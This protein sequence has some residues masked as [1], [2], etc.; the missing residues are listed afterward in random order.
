MLAE[1]EMSKAFAMAY[2]L[3]IEQLKLKAE[4]DRPGACKCHGLTDEHMRRAPSSPYSLTT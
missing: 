2:V 1:L 3:E 4:P